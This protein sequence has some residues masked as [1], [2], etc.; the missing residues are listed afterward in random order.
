L[1][2]L[3]AS[4]RR[5]SGMYI[6][7]LGTYGLH[8][9]P[10]LLLHAGTIAASEG[11]GDELGLRL[12]EDGACTFAFNGTLWPSRL[13]SE[14]PSDTLSRLLTL[15]DFDPRAP[16]LDF[17]PQTSLFS[18]YEDLAVVSALSS[19]FEVTHGS[20]GNAWR[21]SFRCGAPNGSPRELT[22]REVGTTLP[23]GTSIRFLPD[24][25]LFEQ[26]RFSSPGLSWRMEELA[27]R[28]ARVTYWLRDDVRQREER[29]YFE[30]GL[31][32]YAARLSASALPLHAPWNFAGSQDTT[33]V[34]LTLQWCRAPGS[35]LLSWVNGY[36][37]HAGTH[38]VGLSRGLNE[39]LHHFAETSRHHSGLPAYV[40][41]E[42][43]NGLTILLDVTIPQPVWNGPLKGDLVNEECEDDVF[44][45]VRV[46]LRKRFEAEPVVA[47]EILEHAIGR[48]IARL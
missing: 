9:L 7:D 17:E 6:G 4:M 1:T 32:D 31:G 29:H 30:Q 42:L 28:T 14:P 2:D 16:R 25:S 12:E 10:V 43:I 20:G 33:R 8:R 27:A 21:Q 45:L 3:I 22:A 11:R 18:P 35:R 36:R 48:L 39:A 38:L 44:E 46:W 26:T 41:S 37:A 5:R 13:V 15:A 34:R 19:E 40:P 23:R 24:R 47:E